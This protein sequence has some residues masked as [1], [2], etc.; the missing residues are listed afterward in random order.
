MFLSITIWN[1]VKVSERI[2]DLLTRCR[3]HSETDFNIYNVKKRTEYTIGDRK[4][5]SWLVVFLL[6]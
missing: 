2:S 4:I 6:K 3:S 5:Q 1:L